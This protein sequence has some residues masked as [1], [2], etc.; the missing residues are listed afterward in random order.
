MDS[1]PNRILGYSVL[2]EYLQ[3]APQAIKSSYKQGKIV[4]Q[5]VYQEKTAHIQ[6]LVAR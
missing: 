3:S 5:A 4:V 6:E 1:I 2:E